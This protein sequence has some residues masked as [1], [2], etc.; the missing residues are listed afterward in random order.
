MVP[1]MADL[2]SLDVG[3][4]ERWG[5][6]LLRPTLHVIYEGPRIVEEVGIHYP[7]ARYDPFQ[8]MATTATASALGSAPGQYGRAKYIRAWVYNLL[9]FPARRCQVFVERIW[10]E[11]KSIEAERS[12][13]HWADIDGAY[14]LPTIRH[15]KRNGHYIDICST[16]SVD[17]TFQIISQ[18]WTKGYH[19]FAKSGTYKI[20]M[21]AEAAKPCSFGHFNL[22]LNFDQN[23]WKSLQV[24]AAEHGKRFLRWW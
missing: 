11:G 9:G 8:G 14:E 13:L 16:D 20:E 17:K 7:N 15:G 21:T 2:H 22:V 5:A 12:P 3:A 1:D 18:K 10:H 24:V 23:N 4:L 6:L 19:R